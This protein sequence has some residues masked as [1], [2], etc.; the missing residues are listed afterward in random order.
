MSSSTAI[1]RRPIADQDMDF[2]AALYA[3][4]RSEEMRLTGW[5]AEVQAEFLR[6]QFSLQHRYYHQH[7]HGADFELL[8]DRQDQPIGR[9]YTHWRQTGLCVVDIALLPSWRG[10]GIG[11]ALLDETIARAEAAGQSVELHV[12]HD[13]R[14]R[15]W[16]RRLGFVECGENGVYCQM[17]REP[18]AVAA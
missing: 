4:T 15:G 2:L 16:Y 14:A 12:E 18:R 7:F 10:R 6:Q 9:L 17:R 11:T 1:K 3:S 8:L 13:N 5:P